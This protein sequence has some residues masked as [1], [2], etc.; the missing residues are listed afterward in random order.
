MD[1]FEINYLNSV[2][3]T[4]A[5]LKRFLEN[6]KK[7]VIPEVTS[8]GVTTEYLMKVSTDAVYTL[9]EETYR[10]YRKDDHVVATKQELINEIEHIIKPKKL[11]FDAEMPN[12]EWLVDCLYS[13]K[14]THQFFQQISLPIPEREFAKG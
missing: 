8:R 11:G 6:E 2:F 12:K 4:N 13:I 3:K 7:I 5:D 9:S 1:K 14:P 10:H